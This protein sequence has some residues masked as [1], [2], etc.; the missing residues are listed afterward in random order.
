M[1]GI[2]ADSATQELRLLSVCG[3]TRPV[4]CEFRP[5][6]HFEVSRFPFPPTPSQQGRRASG[7]K[8][9]LDWV[10][11]LTRNFVAEIN[12]QNDMLLTKH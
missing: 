12:P 3:L 2:C 10:A 1:Q 4:I 6:T 5:A 11:G 8:V 9:M 7:E